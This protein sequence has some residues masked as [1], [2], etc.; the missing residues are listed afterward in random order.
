MVERGPFMW[1][2][3]QGGVRAKGCGYPGFNVFHLRWSFVLHFLLI[4]SD[5]ISDCGGFLLEL[6]GI[7]ATKRLGMMLR[8]MVMAE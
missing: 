3:P 5:C 6:S 2:E 8:N 7:R 4:C 1:F